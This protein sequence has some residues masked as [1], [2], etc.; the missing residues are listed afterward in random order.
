MFP[1]KSLS[2]PDELE[3]VVIRQ[4]YQV[5]ELWGF[6]KNESVAETLGWNVGEVKRSILSAAPQRRTDGQNWAWENYQRE[7]R[8]NDLYCTSSADMIQAAH[9]LVRE[10]D[11]KISHF[12]ILEEGGEDF[13][14]KH[15]NRFDTWSQCFNPFF[16]DIGGD[17]EAHGVKGLGTKIFPFIE[18]KNRLQCQIVD[19]AFLS[20]VA[21]M[22]PNDA[23]SLQNIQPISLG[24]LTLL[25][26]NLNV[27]PGAFPTDFGGALAV[28][29]HLDNLLQNN[30]GSY[31]RKIS[32]DKAA[33]ATEVMVDQRESAQL[34]KGSI[35]RY[36]YSLDR[37][38]GEMFRRAIRKNTKDPDA[39]AFQSRLKS[40]DVPREAL[41]EIYS[42][43]ANRLAGSGN[44]F[45]RL[46]STTQ[47]LSAVA[48]L[49]EGGRT[50][51]IRDYIASVAGQPNV[52][53]Y[54]P[55]I[56]PDPKT[57]EQQRLVS[58][59]NASMKTG[60][61][62]PTTDSDNDMI[63][64]VGHL[65]AGGAAVESLQQGADKAEVWSY[66][67][68]L[69]PHIAEHLQDLSQDKTRGTQYQQVWNQFQQLT[70]ITDQ[71]ENQIKGEQQARIA[72]Q[73]QQAQVMGKV[74]A[75]QQVGMAKVHADNQV[76]QQ[77]AQADIALKAQK[78]NAELA[79]KAEQQATEQTMQT[80]K[81][82]EQEEPQDME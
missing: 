72:E 49:P 56:E 81:A 61:R 17:G 18:T 42:V 27:V 60:A 55:T 59:E 71:L 48:M 19:G 26:P 3:L 51:V 63:H 41:D 4:N 5:H 15:V 33:S 68:I 58:L 14:Y 75:D 70:A 65:A 40:E 34:T 24:P 44:S 53:R 69:G 16:Y 7:L 80:I 57:Q 25:P 1:D 23:T 22:Q 29:Q 28:G 11:G 6:I 54:Y 78:Q 20:S 2:H 31:K 10:F 50:N 36:Y 43:K 52:E 9:M 79:L 37:L 47:L 67:Q 74:Q 39:Q 76:K 45:T 73:Q 30:T 77:K 21:V 82:F 12:I 35:N 66:L 64:S 62:V 38:F 32:Q 46:Q 13:L 8:N